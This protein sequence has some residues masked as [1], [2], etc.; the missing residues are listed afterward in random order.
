LPGQAG[1]G[2]WPQVRR[3]GD[4]EPRKPYNDQEGEMSEMDEFMATGYQS[5][6]KAMNAFH[7][8]LAHRH[9]DHKQADTMATAVTS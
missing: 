6:E 1:D 3:R 9:G 2:P 5:G 7:Q 8:R 4:R